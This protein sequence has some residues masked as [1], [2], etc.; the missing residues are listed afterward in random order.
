MT[1][2]DDSLVDESGKY[3]V[4]VYVI[5]K[6]Y[7]NWCGPCKVLSTNLK[8]ELSKRNSGESFIVNEINVEDDP[9]TAQEAGVKALPTVVIWNNTTNSE[10]HRFIGN[11]PLIELQK[12]LDELGIK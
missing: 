11:K 3:T 6:F 12:M 1:D 8:F 10:V 2:S 7:A 4:P 9:V 5:N